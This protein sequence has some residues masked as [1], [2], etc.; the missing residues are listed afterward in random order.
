MA[1]VFFVT[2]MIRKSKK[3]K[4]EENIVS[5]NSN[6]QFVCPKCG[7]KLVI[8]T[9]RKGAN[10]GSQFYGCFNYPNCKYTKDL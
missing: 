3:K 10:A 2:R 6:P 7:G 4:N 8:R 1:I 9:A 5:D